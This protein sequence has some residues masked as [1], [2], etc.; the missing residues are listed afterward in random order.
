MHTKETLLLT[1]EKMQWP[2]LLMWDGLLKKKVKSLQGSGQKFGQKQPS[3]FQAKHIIPGSSHTDK[4]PC[5]AP[6][7]RN[8]CPGV[9]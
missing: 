6:L 4:R 7:E 2:P 3:L 8:Q 9:Q 5:K 1:S